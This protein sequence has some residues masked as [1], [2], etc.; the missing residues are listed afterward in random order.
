MLK[1]VV[2]L[3]FLISFAAGLTVG[4]QARP[5]FAAP[6]TTRPSAG[7][8]WLVGQ[9]NLDPQQ[10]EQLEK[11]WARVAHRGGHEQDE[12]R[13]QLSRERDEAIAALIQP[14]DKAKYDQVMKNYSEQREA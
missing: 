5:H 6:P 3:G 13:R 14:A 11:I 10:R 7:P 2:L 12:R 8:G 1:L 4:I 9:L